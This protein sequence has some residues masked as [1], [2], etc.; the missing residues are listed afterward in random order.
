MRMLKLTW[1][2]QNL[3]PITPLDIT[4]TVNRGDMSKAKGILD[5]VAAEIGAREVVAR[6]YRR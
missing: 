2:V 6:Q 4:F 1:I 5:S 3:L